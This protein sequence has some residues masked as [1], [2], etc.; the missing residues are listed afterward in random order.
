MTS[1]ALE[2]RPAPCL[3]ATIPSYPPGSLCF[4]VMR[5]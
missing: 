2:T 4:Q 3:L 1:M 5:P